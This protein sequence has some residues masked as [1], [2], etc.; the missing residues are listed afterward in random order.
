MTQRLDHGEVRRRHGRG[1]GWGHGR[2]K[3]NQEKSERKVRLKILLFL[4][5]YGFQSVKM[6]GIVF[7]EVWTPMGRLSWGGN[8]WLELKH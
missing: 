1:L 4:H 6:G 2:D 8:T 7:Q 5:S 3:G